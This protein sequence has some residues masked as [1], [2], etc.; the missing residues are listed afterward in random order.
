MRQVQETAGR[1][2]THSRRVSS[3]VAMPPNPVLQCRVM[4]RSA[5]YARRGMATCENC[6]HPVQMVQVGGE[7]TA[8]EPEITRFVAVNSSGRRVAV[9]EPTM[10]SQVHAELCER[11]KTEDAKAKLRKELADY[12]KRH[13]GRRRSL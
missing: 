13:R 12:N 6:S 5:P 1:K 4:E 2:T 3:L 8:V 7:L 10:G 9:A 11:Y